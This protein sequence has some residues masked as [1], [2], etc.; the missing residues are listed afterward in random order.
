MPKIIEIEEIDYSDAMMNLHVE[1]NHNYIAN[2]VIVANCHGIRAKVVGDLINKHGKHIAYRFGF[3]GTM[4]KP[5]IDQLTLRG[6]MGEVLL[7]VTA[8][9]LI[10]Q[11]YLAQVEIE[12]VEIDDDLDLDED[13]KPFEF[14]DYSSEKTFLSKSPKRLDFLADLIISKAQ[15]HGNTFV[16][17]SSIKQGQ[18]LQKL[19]K[20]SVF[21]YGASESD[22]RAEWYT[23]FEDKSDLIVIATFGIASTGISINR[24]FCLVMIDAGR[25]FIRCLQSIG[26][27]L[28]KGH[29]KDLAHVV[30][31]YSTLKWSKKHFRERNKYYKEVKYPV[32]KVARYKL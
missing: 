24:I 29:D 15:Q 10:K 26:R 16:L 11:G 6:S 31:V 18:Q 25:S 22:V 1:D 19:I 30:D 5:L 3:T 4:P 14:P 13:G 28:R 23:L 27:S 32:S 2:G 20:D 17:V 7:Q 9:D 12:P 21:L 8:A